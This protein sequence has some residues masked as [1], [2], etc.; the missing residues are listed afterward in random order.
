MAVLPAGAV[1]F[2]DIERLGRSE[3][4][5]A[6]R[7]RDAIVAQYPGRAILNDPLHTLRRYDLLTTLADQ[8]LN[9][10]RAYRLTNMIRPDRFPVFLRREN[11]HTGSISGLLTSQDELDRAIVR[12]IVRGFDPRDP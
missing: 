11:E 3:R 10:F 12:A 7:L 1:I 5:A 8:D 2:S 9:P 4:E 6:G